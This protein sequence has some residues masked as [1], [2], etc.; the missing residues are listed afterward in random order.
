M[1]GEAGNI[2]LVKNNHIVEKR[3]T[4]PNLEPTEWKIHPSSPALACLSSIYIQGTPL[5][6]TLTNKSELNSNHPDPLAWIPEKTWMPWDLFHTICCKVPNQGGIRNVSFP[7]SLLLVS[8]KRQQPKAENA[9]PLS[10]RGSF[11]ITTQRKIP[12]S[13]NLEGR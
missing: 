6:L 4:A 3:K 9:G 11:S 10:F 13:P 7:I 8:Q 1:T 5:F 2:K 12:R